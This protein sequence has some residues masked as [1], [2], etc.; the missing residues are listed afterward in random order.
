VRRL[1]TARAIV[2]NRP[3]L[4][5]MIGAKKM[6]R[7]V[8]LIAN[9]PAVVRHR[10]NVKELARS[11]LDHAPIIERSRRSAGE[12]QANALNVAASRA[13]AQPDV[14]ALFPPRFIRSPTN[15]YPA[16]V[17]PTRSDLFP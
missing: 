5:V 9:D 10:R 16:E 17:Q 12:H 15:R 11:Q 13:Q 3:Y 14:F 4:G 1:R 7:N 8:R 6:Q 2:V